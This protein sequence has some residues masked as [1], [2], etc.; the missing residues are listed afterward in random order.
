MEESYDSNRHEVGNA[1]PLFVFFE[2]T[3]GGDAVFAGIL[4][5]GC[6]DFADGGEQVVFV[7]P[8]KG[9]GRFQRAAQ[10]FGGGDAVLHF[11]RDVRPLPAQ[12]VSADA[13]EGQQVFAQ[14][15]QRRDGAGDGPVI[16]FPVVFRMA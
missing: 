10:L 11:F 6:F 2:G 16:G 1:L 3:L 5:K 15:V 4:G 14:H 9:H 7:F 13:H 8:G 12:R